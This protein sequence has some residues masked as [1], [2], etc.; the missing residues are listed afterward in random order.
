MNE[1]TRLAHLC[2]NNNNNM[3]HNHYMLKYN[4]KRP[5]IKFAVSVR[6]G[7]FCHKKINNLWFA[8]Q[9]YKCI[10][11]F[12]SCFPIFV[13]QRLLSLTIVKLKKLLKTFTNPKLGH[14]KAI[15]NVCSCSPVLLCV[16]FQYCLMWNS[17][18][19]TCFMDDKCSVNLDIGRKN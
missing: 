4:C 18:D 15:L 17:K 1:L 5:R 2:N 7:Q 19:N 3:Q 11:S 14:W 12:G 16:K 8:R 9:K 6:D 10:N 13:T